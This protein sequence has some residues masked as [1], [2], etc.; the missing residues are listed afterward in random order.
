M[1]GN[2]WGDGGFKWDKDL[3]RMVYRIQHGHNPDPYDPKPIKYGIPVA[4]ATY[5]YGGISFAIVE[6]RK[7][8][9]PPGY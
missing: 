5:E 8:K 1:Q 7:F 3:I 6:D 2:L 4:Y 9:S